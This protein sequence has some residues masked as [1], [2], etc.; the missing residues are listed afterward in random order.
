MIQIKNLTKT[1]LIKKR[2]RGFSFGRPKRFFNALDDINLEIKEGEVFG[3]LGPNGAGKTTLIK[4]IS[5]L[6]QPTSGW[7]KIDN[8]P[9]EEVRGKIGLMLGYTMIYYRIT[10]YDNLEYFARLY[11]VKNFKS[12]IKE[13]AEFLGLENWL[14]EYVEHYSTG[15]KSKLALARALIHNPDILLLD[16]P[17]LG[18]DPHIAIDVRKKIKQMKKTIILTTHY[19]E[20]ADQLSDR[21]G[22]LNQG[23]L[24]KVGTPQDL[25]QIMG[26]EKEIS[27]EDVFIKLTKV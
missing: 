4:I 21:I 11:N 3:L 20:E 6:L 23:K 8:K 13:L 24:I 18:L 22:F 25:K 9:V 26:R 5:G 10:G 14:D 15:M 16:E 2:D 17:T 19:M 1:Y 12:R 27:L 7:V